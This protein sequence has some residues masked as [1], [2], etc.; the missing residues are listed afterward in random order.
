MFHRATSSHPTS[1]SLPSGSI[2]IDDTHFVFGLNVCNSFADSTSHTFTLPSQLPEQSFFPSGVNAR[3]RTRSACPLH[4]RTN[5]PVA[6][7]QRRSRL[8]LPPL[9]ASL[10]P[11]ATRTQETL[12]PLPCPSNRTT[13]LAVATSYPRTIPSAPPG[14]V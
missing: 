10:P 2:A 6:A 3:Q 8:S 5:L 11:G 1:S 14:A 13:S 9:A 12:T 7:S 4:S